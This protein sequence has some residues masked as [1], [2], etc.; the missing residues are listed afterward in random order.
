MN[1][2]CLVQVFRGSQKL[3][4]DGGRNFFA[5]SAVYLQFFVQVVCVGLPD[6]KYTFLIF[7]EFMNF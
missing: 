4:R 3:F 7:V 1:D 5:E 2:A 6:Q